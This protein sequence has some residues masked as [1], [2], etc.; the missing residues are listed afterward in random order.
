MAQLSELKWLRRPRLPG[1]RAAGVL[2]VVGFSTN[3]GEE[4]VF[5]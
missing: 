1:V 2:A 3:N 4:G 5:L